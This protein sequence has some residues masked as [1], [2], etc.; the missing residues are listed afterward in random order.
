MFVRFSL[1]SLS[2]A[3][4]WLRGRPCRGRVRRMYT[5]GVCMVTVVVCVAGSVGRNDHDLNTKKMALFIVTAT[6]HALI[7]FFIV[8]GTFSGGALTSPDGTTDGLCAACRQNLPLRQT[9]HTLSASMRPLR[10][11]PCTAWQCTRLAELA[12]GGGGCSGGHCGTLSSHGRCVC[13]CRCRWWVTMRQLRDG[14]HAQRLSGADGQSQGRAA[15]E[16]RDQVQPAHHP[17]WV[18]PIL[19]SAAHHRVSKRDHKRCVN[20]LVAVAGSMASWF[21]FARLY[22]ESFSLSQGT[23]T[24]SQPDQILHALFKSAGWVL[25]YE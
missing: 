10:L 7:I 15:I 3:R 19:I 1:W 22:A 21:G 20:A 25:T 13:R 14:D 9:T 17:R 18:P 16:N 6:S 12:R 5:H 4:A 11:G 24:A 23:H 2:P 8:Y